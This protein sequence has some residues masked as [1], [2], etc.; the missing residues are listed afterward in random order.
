[1]TESKT[2]IIGF[3][4][5]IFCTIASQRSAGPTYSKQNFGKKQVLPVLRIMTFNLWHSGDEVKNGLE[6]IAKHIL[7]VNPDIVALQEVMSKEHLNN[8][9]ALMGPEWSAVC[10]STNPDCK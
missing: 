10:R 8:L 4:L 6:K 9:T 1:M 2:L 7:H 3:L 5:E